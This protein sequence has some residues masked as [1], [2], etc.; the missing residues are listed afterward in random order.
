MLEKIFKYP[1]VLTRHKKAP[2]FEE[3]D[4]YLVYRKKEGC[5]HQ[6]LLIVARELF[7]VV[8][9]LPIPSTSKVTPEQ[10]K[11]AA[12]RWARCQC[13][14]GYAHTLKWSRKFFIHVATDWL[15]FIGRLHEPIVETPAFSGL[16]EDFTK[17]ME[18][19]R[20]LSLITIRNY[21]WHVTKFLRW[22]E[23]YNR[24][25]F[26]VQIPDIDTFL[27]TC[28]NEGW[29]RASVAKIANVLKTFFRY[30]GQRGRCSP[31]ISLGIQCPRLF[32]QETLPSSPTWEDV[33]RLINSLETDQPHD[34]RDRAIIMIFAL[35]ALRSSEVAKLRLDDIDWE[36]SLIS[37][38][39]PK[40]RRIQNYP[41]IPNIGNA[42]ISYL[43]NVRPQNCCREIFLTLKAPI[44]PLSVGGFYNI[45]SRRMGGIGLHTNPRGPHVLRHACTTHLVS[46]GFSLKEIGD[47][48]GHRSTS[49]T[50]IY[51]KVDLPALRQVADF[52]LG[53]LS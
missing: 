51:A 42:I 11:A 20:G 50:R 17:W 32:S 5:T 52:D 14:R 33:N 22:C 7:R 49:A 44:K 24:S 6:T 25:V 34:I 53:G 12:N 23:N 10:I 47:H 37:V 27:A 28:G 15:Q 1:A 38:F 21:C 18:S 8:Q 30:A 19:E 16:I 48:L 41:L 35:Y 13:R 36:N 3:R 4:S 43:R 26:T 2:F 9:V 29:A 46:E 39:R 40:Q 31:S 45:V